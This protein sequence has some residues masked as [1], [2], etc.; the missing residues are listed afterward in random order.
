MLQFTEDQLNVMAQESTQRGTKAKQEIKRRGISVVQEESVGKLGVEE[1][2]S[3]STAV[4]AQDAPLDTT[5]SVT[6]VEAEVKSPVKPV[7]KRKSRVSKTK[8]NK[9]GE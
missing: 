9:T 2:T 5:E 3:N 6:E 7:V 1:K 8:V 4:E